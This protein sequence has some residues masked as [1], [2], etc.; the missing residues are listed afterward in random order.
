MARRGDGLG[1]YRSRV[2]GSRGRRRRGQKPDGIDVPVRLVGLPD[3]QID[4][5]LG[6]L[7]HRP[8]GVSL[9]D[10][11][12]LRHGI[13]TEALEGDREAV[14]GPDGDRLPAR[15]HRAGEADRAGGGR[16][17]GRAGRRAD[18]DASV[19]AAGVGIVAKDE[20]S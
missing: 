4:V 2:V 14:G 9:P 8:H 1:L 15:G 10:L 7:S 5:R 11:E 13:G 3:P 17:N 6:G 16:T 19:L 18:V 20:G 12:P